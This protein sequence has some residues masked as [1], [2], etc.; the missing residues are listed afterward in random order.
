MRFLRWSGEVV[1]G[2]AAGAR[3]AA[4]PAGLVVGLGAEWLARSG[5]SLGAAVADLA[6]GWTLIACGLHIW[7]RRPESRVGPLIAVTGFAWFLGTLAAS[8]IGH[9]AVLGSALVFVHRGPLCHAIVGYPGGRPA[10]R[11]SVMVVVVC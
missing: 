11:M 8:R 3:M 10:G 1:T 5:Q 4:W 2:L 9:V 7:A 6:V